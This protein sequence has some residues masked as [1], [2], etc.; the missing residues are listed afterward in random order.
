M[1]LHMVDVQ[2][3]YTPYDGPDLANQTSRWL[4]VFDRKLEGSHSLFIAILINI[5]II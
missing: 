2:E 3:K 4:G 5:N 1:C